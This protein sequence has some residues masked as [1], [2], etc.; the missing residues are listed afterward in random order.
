MSKVCELGHIYRA[1]ADPHLRNTALL[2][3]VC[4]TVDSAVT[5]HFAF[6]PWRQAIRYHLAFNHTKGF[7]FA[8]NRMWDDDNVSDGHPHICFG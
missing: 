6:Q 3:L 7:R 1:D 2:M 4:H 8:R 5:L